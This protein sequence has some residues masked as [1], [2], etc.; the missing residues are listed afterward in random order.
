MGSALY[1]GAFYSSGLPAGTNMTVLFKDCDFI[2]NEAGKSGASIYFDEMDLYNMMVDDVRF[3]KNQGRR[4]GDNL[5][6][7]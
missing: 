6:V 5:F 3:T 4:Y 7:R 1:G 2:S